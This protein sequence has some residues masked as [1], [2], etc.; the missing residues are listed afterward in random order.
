VNQPRAAVM[1]LISNYFDH[2]TGINSGWGQIPQKTTFGTNGAG[3]LKSKHPS[4]VLPFTQRK[5]LKQNTEDWKQAATNSA[6]T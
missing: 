3:F 1:C 6:L 5:V 2:F 4:S